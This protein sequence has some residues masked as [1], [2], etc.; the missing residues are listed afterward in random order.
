MV[1][2]LVLQVE[3]DVKLIHHQL[4]VHVGIIALPAPFMPL[5]SMHMHCAEM[6]YK[7]VF[8]SLLC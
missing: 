1:H 8:P 3:E 4:K 5:A 7:G 6:G 2:H